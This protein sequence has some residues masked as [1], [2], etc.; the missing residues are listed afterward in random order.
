M[1]YTK[2]FFAAL[3]I[4]SLTT[5]DQS[6]H[7]QVTKKK[8]KL[9]TKAE[10]DKR[11][12]KRFVASF[13]KALDEAKDLNEVSSN[14]FVK[15]F[16]T[17]QTQA[18]DDFPESGEAFDQL[19]IDDKFEHQIALYN[20]L[21]SEM[22]WHCGSQNF[23]LNKT[24]DE[25]DADEDDDIAKLLP[26]DVVEVLKTNWLLAKIFE[27]TDKEKDENKPIEASD[28]IEATQ[29]M[30]EAVRL[31]K[32]A[33]D[34]RDLSWKELYAKNIKKA[35]KQFADY[36]S[37]PCEGS[38]CVGL[39]EK[40]PIFW[41]SAFPFCLHLVREDGKLKIFAIHIYTND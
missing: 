26:P 7:A 18:K 2:I 36:G 30:Q 32:I 3:I 39:P 29:S 12:V 31:L 6:V 14:F 17:H 21:Y 25:E 9:I 23:F 37:K 24:E 33:I 5:F 15:D 1:K 20:F 19:G 41:Q 13:I 16:K 27:L 22:V 34:N 40:T 28:V 11:E 4:F 35:R 8:P 38:S 10:Y